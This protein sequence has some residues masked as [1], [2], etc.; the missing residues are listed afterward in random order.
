MDHYEGPDVIAGS[1]CVRTYYVDPGT[2][3]LGN[4]RKEI[5]REGFLPS[6]CRDHL[7]I[8]WSPYVRWTGPH[9]NN[10]FH[11]E[12]MD[13]GHCFELFWLTPDTIPTPHFAENLIYDYQ[14]AYE[15]KHPEH[16]NDGG[17]A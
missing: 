3:A 14:T 4:A 7:W 1:Q 15:K 8:N 17:I 5:I 10:E 11:S 2:Y 13:L 12:Y 9:W 6:N 16:F